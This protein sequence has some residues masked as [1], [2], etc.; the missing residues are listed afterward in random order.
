M[1][2]LIQ[3][4]ICSIGKSYRFL[5][6]SLN[7]YVVSRPKTQ[8]TCISNFHLSKHEMHYRA[9]KICEIITKDEFAK[10]K[11]KCRLFCWG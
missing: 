10:C 4:S 11:K 5:K 7:R 1:T 9:Y 2:V 6:N 3:L 8:S